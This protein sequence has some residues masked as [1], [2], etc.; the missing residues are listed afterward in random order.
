MKCFYPR[1]LFGLFAQI[2]SIRAIRV[3]LLFKKNGVVPQGAAIVDFGRC[4][5]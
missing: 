5:C 2:R 1:I 3:L 4:I